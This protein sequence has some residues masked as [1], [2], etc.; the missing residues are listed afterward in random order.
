MLVP[1]FCAVLL[2]SFPLRFCESQLL[3]FGLNDDTTDPCI[4]EC[5]CYNWEVINTLGDQ[6]KRFTVNCTGMKFGLFQGMNVPKNLPFNTT[7]LVVSEYLLGT[8]NMASFPNHNFPLNPMLLSVSLSSCHVTYLSS[9]TFQGNSFI[10]IK[11]ITFSNN[12][13]DLLTEGT[14]WHL[15]Y[16]ENILLPKNIL[17][18][19]QKATFRNLP[20]VH[21]IDLSHNSITEI[22]QGAFDNLPLLEILDLSYNWLT[23]I[24]MEDVSQLPSLKILNLNGNTWN[25]S[26]EMSG[27]LN[28][29][30]VLV[31]SQAI[32]LYP[33][34]LNGTAL[35]HLTVEN[36]GH[37]STDYSL[38]DS[39]IVYICISVLVM[40]APWLYYICLHSNRSNVKVIG[41]IQFNYKDILG[42]KSNVFKGK[43]QDR[44]CGVAIKI[45]P[46]L[47]AVKELNI[48]L[49]LSEKEPPHLNVIQYLCT[50]SDG[51]NTFI[52]LELC[53]GNLK[54]AI[55]HCN[56]EILPY[57]TPKC[58]LLQIT[59]GIK[60]LHD[61]KVQ[62]RDI[63]PQKY[64]VEI[65]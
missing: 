3:N 32:C 15:P 28:M 43:V 62:H 24:P 34:S 20:R 57:L 12:N 19:V 46:K 44:R 52:A 33:S 2:L 60:F 11:N 54:N 4:E 38:D 39:Y 55:S 56:D 37:C 8:L 50:E 49:H 18:K 14:F 65:P 16:V 25:C 61:L 10:S 9:E 31:E 23:T 7:D 63:K 5:K 42:S 53:D 41:K 22:Q 58:C 59:H 30:S 6:E 51:A 64:L 26:C 17:R 1:A 47:S 36:F 35:K 21:T 13:F 40:C 45:Y 48:L 29:S 27:I